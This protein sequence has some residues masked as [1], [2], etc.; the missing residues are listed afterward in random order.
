MSNASKPVR[1]VV[2]PVAGL[3][4]RFLPATKTIP[5]EMLPIVDIPTVQLNVEECI[6]SGIDEIIFVT[7]RGKSQIEDHFD[8]AGE[9]EALLE[10]RGKTA[11]LEALQRL[12]TMA[13]FVSVR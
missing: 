7:A 1:K 9:L 5:K 12:T 4:T 10:K 3:G 2:L 6:A 13:K 11:D 8:R